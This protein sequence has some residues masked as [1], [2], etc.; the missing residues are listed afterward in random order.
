MGVTLVE[1]GIVYL[2]RHGQSTFNAAGRFQGCCDEPELT[3]E[4][5]RTADA[6]G[7]YLR[8]AG[9]QAV[10]ASP[11][12]RA[13]QTAHRIHDQVRRGD[14]R[15]VSFDTEWDLREIDLPL[16]ER[17]TVASIVSE[18]GGDYQI[19]R[20]HPHHFQMKERRPVVDLY[21]RAEGL[22]ARLLNRFG[23]RTILLATHGGAGRALIGT[24]IG[25]PPSSYHRLQQSNG[26]ISTLE[27]PG[28]DFTQARLTAV[29]VTD[30]EGEPL[31]ETKDSKSGPRVLLVPPGDPNSVQHRC[32]AMILN[33]T[34]LDAVF[35]STGVCRDSVA[36]LLRGGIHS[37]AT[38][39]VA[40]TLP[41]RDGSPATILWM[42]DPARLQSMLANVLGLDEE[43]GTRFCP[44]PLTFTVLHYNGAGKFPVVQ[45]MNLYD[46]TRFDTTPGGASSI[47][48]A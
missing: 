40:E 16:W 45:G 24:A 48:S 29:N 23:G 25:I 2:I 31:S 8:E 39:E 10:V 19:W 30:Y 32:A 27:F 41:A 35:A 26:G 44:I 4:G 37:D 6:A 7:I 21:Q 20:D 47:R 1:M 46:A 5:R 12:R 17:K 28:N 15:D 13:A 42:V 22:W 18:Y 36:E 11:L 34:R 33:Q 9:L 43:G 38:V 14:S 3:E